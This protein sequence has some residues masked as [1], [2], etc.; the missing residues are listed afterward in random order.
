MSKRGPGYDCHHDPDVEGHDGEHDDVRDGGLDEVEDRLVE[1]PD[2]ST[3]FGYMTIESM[4]R[5]TSHHSGRF[6][7]P[8]DIITKVRF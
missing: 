7:P 1:V 5:V 8:V 6:K 2:S 4:H 3:N